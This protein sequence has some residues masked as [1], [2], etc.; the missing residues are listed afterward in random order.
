MIEVSDSFMSN[1]TNLLPFLMMIEALGAEIAPLSCGV[2]EFLPLIFI[3]KRKQLG[4]F[5]EMFRLVHC[6]IMKNS[7]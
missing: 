5:S 6:K 7:Q 1:F 3:S 2:S 4:E